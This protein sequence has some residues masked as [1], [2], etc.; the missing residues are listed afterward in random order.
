MSKK[1]AALPSWFWP[2]EVPRT[3]GVP[4]FF[5]EE[6]LVEKWAEEQPEAPAIVTGEKTLT[7]AAL[8]EQV[9]RSAAFIAERAEGQA[10]RVLV[11]VSSPTKALLLI[12]AALKARSLVHVTLFLEGEALARFA[13]DIVVAQ[14]RCDPNV[15][16][17]VLS[18][19]QV[20]NAPPSHAVEHA[21]EPRAPALAFSTDRD[22]LAL[23]SHYGLLAGAI[24]FAAFMEMPH[25]MRFLLNQHPSRWYGFYS[26]MIALYLGGSVVACDTEQVGATVEM[27]QKWRP[28]AAFF[29]PEQAGL[30]TQG[31][32]RAARKALWRSCEWTFMP[33]SGPFSG[34]QRKAL[35]N[36]FGR[37]ILTVYGLPE[38]GP[39]AASHPSWHLEESVGI[40]L[41][42]AELR[43]VDPASRE[44]IEVPWELLEFAGIEV[45]ASHMMLGYDDAK[46][47]AERLRRRWFFTG[48]L[49]A[50]DAN[51]LYYLLP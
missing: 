46:E 47:T 14:G 33:V 11:S 40:P 12:L 19:E 24:A 23:H 3:V 17:V 10:K 25:G 1:V 27:L 18:D 15:A 37:P 2:E 49:A 9:S 13:P 6:A 35:S 32:T 5:L 20:L 28:D 26:A 38:S 34:R 44:A 45:K 36:L 48:R 7:Y 8:G 30:L 16:S 29:T 43:P 4:P 41:T 31:M 21:G 50:M 42:N 39:V 51:G 22:L